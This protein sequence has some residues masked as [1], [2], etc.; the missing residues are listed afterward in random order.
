MVDTLKDIDDMPSAADMMASKY[1]SSSDI[2]GASET[3]TITGCMRATETFD[4]GRTDR[5]NII[6]IK[7][8]SGESAKMIA[9][10]TNIAAMRV[11]FGD[12]TSAWI[13]KRIV[14]V[15]DE[16]RMK[17]ETVV[18]LRISGSPD[19]TA[20]RAKAYAM[21]WD[22]ADGRANGRRGKTSL[23]DRLKVMLAKIKVKELASRDAPA[24]QPESKP[25]REPGEDM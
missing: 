12:T 6:S 3:V 8:A 13:G 5:V 18:C 1:L 20:G 16:D 19:A 22:H 9:C 4:A 24:P 7:R 17:G 15:P 25:M 10:K 23:I 21:A 2:A 11:L 14:L